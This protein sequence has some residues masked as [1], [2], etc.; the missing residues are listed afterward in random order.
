MSWL[1]SQALVEAYAEES[2]SDG[3]P[4]ERSNSTPTP[5]AYW[6]PDKTTDVW[7]RFPS[8]MTCEPLTDDHG[9]GVL[10]SFLADFPVK[11]SVVQERAQG[12]TERR[13]DSGEKWQGS[14][15]KYDQ[16]ASTWRTHQCSLLGG[17]TEFS[18]TWPQWGSMQNGECW[19][20]TTLVRPTSGKESGFWRTP[21]A[22]NA[23]EYAS[24]S[25][26]Q[27]NT[28]TLAAQA[29]GKLNPAWVEWLM[30][31]PLGWTGL[32][33]SET[34]KCQQWRQQHLNCL[35]KGGQHDLS[36]IHI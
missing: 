28:P 6:W 13:A 23:K 31:W 4:S 19:E 35:V 14:F 22:H 3:E 26:Y 11:I 25:E 33:A 30:G 15:A 34:A 17:F 5:Q 27:R 7:P 16:G 32:N 2:F 36:L 21:T 20:R 8:G 18:E 29:G 1:Y 9:K 10:M 24:P 12:L